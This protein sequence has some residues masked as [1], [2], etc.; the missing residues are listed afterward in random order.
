[1]PTIPF[2]KLVVFDLLIFQPF[3]EDEDVLVESKD[4]KFLWDA[5]VV[6]VS[7]DPDT[8]RVN[9]YLVHYKNW[10]SRFDQRVAPDRVVEPNKINTEV[11]GE[12]TQ[13]FSDANDA[14]PPMLEKMFAYQFLNAKKR[15]RSTPAT[16]TDIFETAFARPS[17][18]QDEKLLGLLKGAVLLIEA[19]LPRGSVGSSKN[20][21]WDHEA[22][23]AW[24]NFVKDAQG[25]E[26]LMKC[27]LLLEDAISPDWF[28]SQATQLYASLPKQWRAMGEASL[29][30]IALRVSVLD[31]CLKYQQKKKKQL[32]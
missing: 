6:D 5:V 16:K 21:S 7:K 18:S 9:G 8:E 20:G 1:M 22:A 28:H 17:A 25:P 29:S 3:V 10:S 2:L 19:A 13:D 23:A 14:S 30:G 24:R 11:Q 31:R 4:G 15:A 32:D 12:V 27:V 26:S